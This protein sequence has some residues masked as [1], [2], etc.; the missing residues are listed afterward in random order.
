MNV[1]H[2]FHS[3]LKTTENWAFSLIRNLPDTKCFIASKH[4]EKCNFYDSAF[5]YLEFPLR[6]I[7]P[8]SGGWLE[9]RYN[10]F[11]HK[12]I[13]RFYPAFLGHYASEAELIHSHFSFVGWDYRKLALKMNVPHIIS[14]YGFDYE[15]MP[16]N[17]PKWLDRYR[18][19]FE[20]ADLFLC[21]GEH[22][23]R[24]LE[25]SGC[26]THKIEV[27]RLGVECAQIPCF[28][29]QK[30]AG[31]LHLLQIA[32]LTEKKGHRYT[33]E[34]FVTALEKC[35]EMTLTIIGGDSE[36]IKARLLQQIPPDL[37]GTR[38]FF[39]DRI[40]FSQL[41]NFMKNYHLFIHPSCYSEGRDCEGGA[42]VVLL[43]AQATGMPVVATTHCD[44][45]SV[46]CDGFSGLLAAEK[47]TTALVNFINRFYAMGQDEYSRFSASA[48]LHVEQHYDVRKNAVELKR[49]YQRAIANH[50]GSK[51]GKN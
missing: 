18:L 20:Q 35:P 8:Q 36:G 40:D 29:R 49:I 1:L 23:A 25:K 47:D 11:A 26:P 33:V 50:C 39:I 41:H 21:E 22:G 17:E 27:C 4:F 13:R 48:R 38:I 51:T 43:D 12:M 28:D 44:I 9:K 19:L 10:R 42:P 31:E 7:T 46:V 45:P 37:L 6:K 32:S 15:W 34:A 5:T 2:C 3:Y 24:I 30:V 16:H 14:F